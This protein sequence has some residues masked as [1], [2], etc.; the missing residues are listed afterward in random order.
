MG[1]RGASSGKSDRG[2]P[3]GSQYHTR[4]E[5]GNIKFVE[6]NPGAEEQ[7]LETMT[8]GRVYVLVD[9]DKLKSIIYFDNDLKRSKRIDL[10]HYHQKMKPHVQHGYYDNETDKA[11]GVKKGATKLNPEEQKMVD[12]VVSLWQNR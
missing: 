1:G 2:N 9:G 6:K 12:R 5:S 7:L 3:Y 11:N 8:R 10:D 4:F